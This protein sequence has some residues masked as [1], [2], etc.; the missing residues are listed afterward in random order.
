MNKIFC[1][2]LTEPDYGSDAS[3]LKTS[4]RK[5][6]GGYLINGQ[7]RWI[8]NGTI[9]DHYIIWARNEDEDGKV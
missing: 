1:F 3:N 2:G 5:T 7:K 6:E 4:A 8:G 9:A